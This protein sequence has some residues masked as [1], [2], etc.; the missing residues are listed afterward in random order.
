MISTRD[1]SDLSMPVLTAPRSSVLYEY[2]LAVGAAG[3]GADV[4]CDSR[5]RGR[6]PVE[7]G[8]ETA[9]GTGAENTPP[10]LNLN[11]FPSASP[12]AIPKMPA[13]PL[14]D[15]RI[16]CWRKGVEED[17]DEELDENATDYSVKKKRRS[18]S[19]RKRK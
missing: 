19:S 6:V 3:A 17:E 15:F 4:L 5:W 9:T 2:L 7:E 8:A 1:G 16:H 18:S 10:C 11:V 13:T 14:R 12:K